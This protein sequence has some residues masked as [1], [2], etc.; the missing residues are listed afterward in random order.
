[1]NNTLKMH[2]IVIADLKKCPEY[3]IL[4][5]QKLTASC[6]AK[7]HEIRAVILSKLSGFF[8]LYL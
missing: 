8:S 4:T 5:V 6:V 2:P 3:T 7:Q 1:M